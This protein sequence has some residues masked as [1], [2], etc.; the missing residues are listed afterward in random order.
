MNL[1]R[2]LHSLTIENHFFEELYSLVQVV[3]PFTN[4]SAAACYEYVN[5]TDDC[6]RTSLDACQRCQITIEK[7]SPA[8]KEICA[9]C[10]KDFRNQNWVG[11]DSV[12]LLNNRTQLIDEVQLI[13]QL[14]GCNSIHNGNEIYRASNTTFDFGEFFKNSSHNIL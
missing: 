12:F 11:R 5:T 4:E 7:W 14:P 10:P 3:K 13:C 6:Q 8:S 2:I 9:T 1:K